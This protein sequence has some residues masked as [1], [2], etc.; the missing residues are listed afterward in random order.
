MQQSTKVWLVGRSGRLGSA[1][2]YLLRRSPYRLYP[3]DIEDIDVTDLKQVENF[4]ERV[5][6][7]IIIDCAA[8]N[9]REWCEE[10]PEDAFRLH[11]MGG[12]NLAIMA[13]EI[14]AHLFYLSSDF[15]FDGLSPFP[16]TE[17]DKVNPQT[18]YGKSKLMGEELVRSLCPRH[19]ILRSS[20]M[21]GK[22]TLMLY[23]DEAA[24]TG[25]VSLSTKIV[26]S[27]T[28]SLEL[29]ETVI[30]FL[31]SREMGTFHISSEG[32][33]S[34]Q[35]W[36][37]ELLRLVGIEAE[38]VEG[39]KKQVFEIMRPRYSVLDNFMLRLTGKH[40]MKTWQEG[41]ARFVRERRVTRS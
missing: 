9:D 23:I 35:E 25:K 38:I 40:P 30:D 31:S 12:R 16:Y 18:V 19:T 32:A 20:W 11:A 29:A 34:I 28:S 3:T 4:A 27:P 33:C 21:Y 8:K 36:V 10:N 39:G 26:G 24:K 17:F 2:E 1:L 7:D 41:L 6:P 15:V 37:A 5:R 14:G 13:N 22:K